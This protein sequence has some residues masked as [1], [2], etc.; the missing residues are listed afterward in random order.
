MT[1][2]SSSLEAWGCTDCVA[3]QLAHASGTAAQ[4]FNVGTSSFYVALAAGAGTLKA[5]VSAGGTDMTLSMYSMF[6]SPTQ[7]YSN[8]LRQHFGV[9]WPQAQSGYLYTYGIG[10][11]HIVFALQHSADEF[12]HFSSIGCDPLAL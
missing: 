5:N 6:T 12:H 1:K 9:L 10:L 3:A 4:A 7:A 8:T 2:S 11:L